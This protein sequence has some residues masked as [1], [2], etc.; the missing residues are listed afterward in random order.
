MSR[1]VDTIKFLF[2]RITFLQYLIKS[3]IYYEQNMDFKPKENK[4]HYRL[5]KDKQSTKIINN[6][7]VNQEFQRINYIITTPQKKKKN[8]HK[9]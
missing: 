5:T 4:K 8:Y 3:Y 6:Q 7:I 9:A 2:Y 1:R